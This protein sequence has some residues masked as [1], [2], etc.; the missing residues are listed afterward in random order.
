MEEP[1]E[2]SKSTASDISIEEDEQFEIFTQE[3]IA[4]ILKCNDSNRV[5]D[6]A[7]NEIVY[8]YMSRFEHVTITNRKLTTLLTGRSAP[9]SSDREHLKNPIVLPN[10]T[11]YLH[12]IFQDEPDD[13]MMM[14]TCEALTALYD[15]IEGVEKDNDEKMGKILTE[16]RDIFASTYT[17]TERKQNL[18]P[19][20][21]MISTSMYEKDFSNRALSQQIFSLKAS[22]KSKITIGT[23]LEDMDA[24]CRTLRKQLE[25]KDAE[26][27]RLL[28][29][30]EGL[31][32]V[33]NDSRYYANELK[34]HRKQLEDKETECKRWVQ[35]MAL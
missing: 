6:V 27:Q 35:F 31:Q 5:K 8:L 10:P 26:C 30:S 29:E 24:E 14:A 34:D 21:Q 11:C 3:Y 25:D 23:K 13:E 1:N 33:E 2:F 9:E 16:V 32:K 4:K 7:L 17:H 19:I 28:R 22:L 12:D 15:S 20:I 18:E